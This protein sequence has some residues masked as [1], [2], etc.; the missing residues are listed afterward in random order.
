MKYLHIVGNEFKFVLPIITYLNTEFEAREHLFLLLNATKKQ[1]AVFKR[2]KNV[3]ILWPYDSEFKIIRLF[4]LFIKVPISIVLLLLY[5]ARA[6]KIFVHGL[7]DIKVILF[8]YLIRNELLKSTWIIWGG[9]DLDDE[10]N[11]LK[12]GVKSKVEYY[13][14]GNFNEYMTYIK[15]DYL[16]AV[17]LYQAKGEF[18]ECLIYKSNVFNPYLINSR[19]VSSTTRIMVGN[20]ADSENNHLEILEKLE[21]YKEHDIHIFCV[22]SYGEKPWTP[23]YINKIINFGTEKFGSKFTAILEYIKYDDYLE[24]LNSIDIAFF[25]H[26]YQQAMGNTISLLG[27][28]KKVYLRNKAPHKEF[29]SRLGVHTFSMDEI[30]LERISESISTSNTRIVT[31]HFSDQKL[32][33]QWQD[34]LEK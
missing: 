11:Y 8:Y 34:V 31:E 30:S 14:K 7:F 22:L 1:S 20:S 9:G 25:D 19:N 3:V 10:E 2:N 29:L 12:K 28:G 23:G 24:F 18:R 17:K 4:L 5:T 21:R 16:V 15:E 33:N 26:K 13:V 6:K 27:F 32:R